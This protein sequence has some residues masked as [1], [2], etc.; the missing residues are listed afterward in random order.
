MYD[1]LLVCHC[2]Y[3]SLS[4]VPFTSYLTLNN[5]VILKCGLD[6]GHSRSLTLVPFKSFGAVSYS[7]SIVTLA[8][9]VGPTCLFV[10]CHATLCIVYVVYAVMHAV[11]VK[12]VLS[13]NE[14]TYPQTCPSSRSK[15]FFPREIST[16]A[17]SVSSGWVS[18]IWTRLWEQEAYKTNV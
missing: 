1:F 17:R 11:S 13:W 3:S 5:T 16:W 12:T 7:P 14:L 6:R 18:C 8:V 9:S 10:N 2:N 15:L 4:L